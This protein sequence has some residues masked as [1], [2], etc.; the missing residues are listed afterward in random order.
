ML[1]TFDSNATDVVGALISE[2]GHAHGGESTG[3]DG[4][5]VTLRAFRERQRQELSWSIALAGEDR[6][7]AIKADL[8]GALAALEA[9]DADK[10]LRLV[11][12]LVGCLEAPTT[13]RRKVSIEQDE[14]RDVILKLLGVLDERGLDIIDVGTRKLLKVPFQHLL[15][16]MRAQNLHHLVSQEQW[17]ELFRVASCSS[18]DQERQFR[19][20]ANIEK[21]RR[22]YVAH[23]ERARVNGI[24]EP[25]SRVKA[26][27]VVIHQASRPK[28]LK[29]T[30]CPH[31]ITSSWY[32][33]H[34]TIGKHAVLVPSTGHQSCRKPSAKAHFRPVD[35]S[36]Y[37]ADCINPC[38]HATEHK[39]C[40][41]CNPSSFCSHGRRLWVCRVCRVPRDRK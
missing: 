32:Y 6:A 1:H 22:R 26:C 36:P 27:G 28:V 20:S 17:T 31:T 41:L 11:G 23:S 7:R 40:R 10:I 2:L 25:N 4:S 15:H 18:V 38:P 14:L 24:Y 35:G 29:C 30:K 39:H 12:R 3:S 13:V 16:L 33:V 8:R 5:R 19:H 21:P 34:P 9:R 37:K